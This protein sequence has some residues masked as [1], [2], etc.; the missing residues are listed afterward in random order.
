MKWPNGMQVTLPT[1]AG[2]IGA[3]ALA[4]AP[5][6][7]FATE[8][9]ENEVPQ[10]VEA[11]IERRYGSLFSALPH[12]RQTGKLTAATSTYVTRKDGQ[13]ATVL[14]FARSDRRVTVLNELIHLSNEDVGEFIA[15][16]FARYES[17][18]NISFNAITADLRGL[19]YPFQRYFC[20]EDIVIAP[21]NS[22][23]DYSAS[24]KKSTRKSI[25]RHGNLLLRAHP[26]YS[27]AVLPSQAVSEELVRHIIGFN[28][29]RMA[30][31]DRISAY[32]EEES[33]W[34]CALASARGLVG[35]VTIDGRVCA[36]AV[37]CNVAGRYF[38]LV[39]AHDPEYDQFGLG[40]LCCYRTICECIE[41]DGKEVHL[42]WGRHAYKASLCGVP[43]R[44][45]RIAV[46]RSRGDYLRNLD[47][48]VVAAASGCLREA[49]LWL[50]NAEGQE[51][52]KGRIATRLWRFL[53]RA[54]R[55][56]AAMK[57]KR[58][59]R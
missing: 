46:Y 16:V 47:K 6:A 24:L 19:P 35:V 22:V 11:E 20:A 10:F 53:R 9:Y 2:P 5:G 38:L 15:F 21:I 30:D 52:L 39:T 43:R 13:V 36:G 23:D 8:C 34:V 29:A 7:R 40:I 1:P 59:A 4:P 32:T 58:P 26:S 48:V 50:V 31:K 25:R 42:L 28:K 44:F 41:R 18:R 56:V 55:S 37:C 12:L 51:N 49:R 45:D 17:V 27:Y 33:D 57:P 54:K 3:A 14:L